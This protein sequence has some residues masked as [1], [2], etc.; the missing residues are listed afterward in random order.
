LQLKGV[1]PGVSFFR[2]RI[3]DSALSDADLAGADWSKQPA[4][5]E[6]TVANNERWLAVDRGAGPFRILYVSGRP[7][8]EYKFMR[9][10]LAA[11]P[12]IQMPSLIRIAKREPKFE[13]RGRA[14]ETSNPLFRGFGAQQPE[15][16]QRY[17]QPVFIRLEAKDATELRDGFPKAPEDLFGTY[18]A[19]ILDDVE[20]AF[21][22]Q[23]QQRLVEKFVAE[24]GGALLTLGGQESYQ[25]G[26]YEHTPIGRMLPVYLDRVSRTEA[27]ADAR[28]N[29]TREGWLEPWMRLRPAEP[30]EQ[31]RL[32]QMPGFYSVNQVMSVKPGASM[33]ATLNTADGRS[34]PAVVT[35]RFGEGRIVSLMV[36]DLWRWGMRDPESREDMEKFWRQLTRWLVVD[37]PDRIDLQISTTADPAAS[38]LVRLAV[39]VH[40]EAFQPMDDALVRL[41]VTPPEGEKITLYGEPS[42]KEAGLFEA[43]FVN[44][45]T[46]AYRVDAVVDQIADT[47]AEETAAAP[48]LIGRKTSGWVHDPLP[49]ALADVTAKPDILTRLAAATGGE[50]FA[51]QDAA[52]LPQRLASLQVPVMD[53]LVEPFWHRPWAFALLLGLLV[54]EWT[55]RRSTGTL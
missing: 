21:F 20:A 26:G 54:A 2:V 34:L 48:E 16:T 31:K 18:R 27:V 46:G 50:M 10:A 25:S 55:L 19:I 41:E 3:A 14:G 39:R 29:L 38:N 23:E 17:D 36:G 5:D 33:L 7:N 30:D 11:D 45:S 4:K 9:R 15:E 12:E 43:E 6:I 42:L 52:R 32:A 53:R 37:V 24:R 28:L 49:I 35:Q 47:A 22:T 1:K 51:L 13:W 40:N 8:W 44:Q